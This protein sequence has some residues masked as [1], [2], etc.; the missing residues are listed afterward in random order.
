MPMRGNFLYWLPHA[1]NFFTTLMQ[2]TMNKPP[3]PSAAEI[4]KHQKLLL[5]DKDRYAKQE[6]ILE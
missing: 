3:F 1:F 2:N 6:E 4:K 5:E